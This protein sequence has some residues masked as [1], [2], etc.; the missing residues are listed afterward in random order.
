MKKPNVWVKGNKLLNNKS[1][2][3]IKI[4]DIEFIYVKEYDRNSKIKRSSLI[5]F[6]LGFPFMLIHPIIG[7]IVFTFLLIV[8]YKLT[9]KYE[10]RVTIFNNSDIGSVE[11]GLH[12]SNSREEYDDVVLEVKSNQ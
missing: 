5:S 3:P 4:K 7:F 8:N 2:K 1:N 12:S 9:K 10:L 6:V 11:S